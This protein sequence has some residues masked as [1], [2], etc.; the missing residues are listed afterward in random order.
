MEVE[1]VVRQVGE[2]RRREVDCVRAV[3]LEGV[4]GDLDRTRHISRV[5]HGAKIVLEL[6]R[7]RRR[8]HHLVL[9]AADH[10]LDGAQQPAPTSLGLEQ[11][12]NQKRR[13]RLAVRARDADDGQLGGRIAVEASRGL[14]HRRAYIGDHDLGDVDLYT[15]LHDQRHRAGRDGLGGEIMAV[16]GEAGDAEEQG[17]RGHAAMIVGEAGDLERWRSGDHFVHEHLGGQ[18]TLGG[19]WSARA[20]H[21]A[22]RACAWSL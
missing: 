17:S 16:T 1:M 15:A 6:D 19:G 4:R 5:E 13:R 3:E 10:A 2:D 20:H 9:D 22:P 11:R 14:R 12:P 18:V 7:L 21:C 8:T